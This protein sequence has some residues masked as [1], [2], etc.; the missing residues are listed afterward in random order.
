[1]TDDEKRKY[2]VE[3]GWIEK[4]IAGHK[5]LLRKKGKL[6]P[7]EHLFLHDAWVLH[8][9]ED[10]LAEIGLLAEGACDE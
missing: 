10:P 3:R 4:E 8:C 7:Y 1:M 2:L 5:W 9:Q 6:W